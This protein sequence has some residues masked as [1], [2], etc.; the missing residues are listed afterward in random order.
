MEGVGCRRE[1]THLEAAGHRCGGTRSSE[2]VGQRGSELRLVAQVEREV[3]SIADH[4]RAGS[5]LFQQ[6]HAVRVAAGFE[7]ASGKV[8]EDVDLLNEVPVATRTAKGGLVVN[9]RR[10]RPV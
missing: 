5:R 2:R 4:V 10:V 1:I 8:A 3:A 7:G 6:V 9:G